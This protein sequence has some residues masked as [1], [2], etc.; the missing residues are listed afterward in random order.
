MD[1]LNVYLWE[2]AYWF[3]TILDLKNYILKNYSKNW[4]SLL[5]KEIKKNWGWNLLVWIHRNKKLKELKINKIYNL[6]DKLEI[7][8]NKAKTKKIKA[9]TDKKQNK[10][11]KDIDL[12]ILKAQIEID[13]MKYNYLS[14]TKVDKTKKKNTYISLF[15]WGGGGCS[16]LKSAWWHGLISVDIDYKQCLLYNYNIWPVLNYDLTKIDYTRLLDMVW[17]SRLLLLSPPCQFFSLSNMNNHIHKTIW[18]DDNNQNI[19][20]SIF[21]SVEILNP[22]I[23]LFENV[24]NITTFPFFNEFVKNIEKSWYN[25]KVFKLKV[26]DFGWLTIRTRCIVLFTKQ[27]NWITKFESL[28]EKEKKEKKIEW[29]KNKNGETFMKWVRNSSK[30]CIYNVKYLNERTKKFIKWMKFNNNFWT[31]SQKTCELIKKNELVEYNFNSELYFLSYEQDFWPT[32]LAKPYLIHPSWNRYLT[33]QELKKIQWYSYNF[34]FLDLN[35]N[36]VAYSIWES[37]SPILTKV[38]GKVLRKI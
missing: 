7:K 26:S 19:F 20:L 21:K 13:T 32:L 9:G 28:L 33:I 27:K 29:L 3:N 10:L 17:K 23:I 30:Y 25:S 35:Y 4:I 8:V 15:C 1:L 38:L 12:K 14:W 22:E 6:L 36:D 5:R 37:I 24:V 18:L 34:D 31:P 2:N 16:W 11:R